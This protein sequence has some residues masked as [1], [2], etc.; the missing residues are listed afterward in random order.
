MSKSETIEIW[1]PGPH[2]EALY[3]VSDWG[4]VRSLRS[5]PP[6]LLALTLD[7]SGYHQVMLTGHGRQRRFLVHRLVL[8]AHRGEV[9][10]DGAQVNHI[11]GNK[12]DNCLANLEWVTPSE[13]TRHAQGLCQHERRT[14]RVPAETQQTIREQ[15]A[16]MTHNA[17]AARFGLHRRT[18]ERI[19][20][21]PVAAQA[22]AN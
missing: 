19:L 20:A 15:S 13:N 10:F 21:R 17:L 18:I 7:S 3:E 8:R 14:S 2:Y 4:N 5:T 12:L 22:E 9:P 16:H 11:N 1:A 6:R